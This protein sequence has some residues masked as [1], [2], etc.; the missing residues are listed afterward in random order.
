[1][2]LNKYIFV[3]IKYFEKKKESQIKIA[4][5]S[6]IWDNKKG[7][8]RLLTWHEP[9][10][11]YSIATYLRIYG[12][13]FYR[14]ST[15]ISLGNLTQMMPL[16]KWHFD[17]ISNQNELF[18]QQLIDSSKEIDAS[19]DGNCYQY[20]D[21]ECSLENKLKNTKFPSKSK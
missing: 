16:C 8:F 3:E 15:N 10:L 1:M 7:I 18:V 4:F 19:A 11:C 13:S 21:I 12:K 2:E 14:N 9:L 6:N 20:H 5:N 17:S